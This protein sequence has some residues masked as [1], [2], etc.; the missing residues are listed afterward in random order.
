VRRVAFF[1]PITGKAV[2]ERRIS[3]R[4]QELRIDLPEFQGS[5]AI[6]LKRLDP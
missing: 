6:K 5:I 3:V 2:G 1:D 4:D